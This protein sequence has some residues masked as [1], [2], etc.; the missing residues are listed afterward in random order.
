VLSL[1]VL[2]ALLSVVYSDQCMEIPFSLC[3]GEMP[4][5][6]SSG[7]SPGMT[8]FAGDAIPTGLV[9]YWSFDD[10]I[11][12]DSSRNKNPVVPVP[13]VGPGAGFGQSA[14]FNSSTGAAI[15]YLPIY[16]S[17]D[18][19]ISF[20][21]FLLAEVFDSFPSIIHKGS[22]TNP[23]PSI[24]LSESRRLHIR[25]GTAVLESTSR[26]TIGRWTSVSY[27]KDSRVVTIYIDGR[28]DAQMLLPTRAYYE[29]NK[30]HPIFLSQ[31]PFH[32][33]LDMFLDELRIYRRAVTP[34]LS[35]MSLT[36]GVHLGCSNCEFE[37]GLA[38]CPEGLHMCNQR[39]LSTSA[40][41]HARVMGW[42]DPK[43][44]TCGV[45]S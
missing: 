10:N 14:S 20:K 45:V 29:E 42:I 22:Q 7:N 13:D 9:G 11:A 19:T 38:S 40:L 21:I 36:G 39:E 25:I 41:L 32:T 17:K 4:D 3:I 33:G 24:L 44:R 18:F 5:P 31:S 12:Q 23:Q 15:A 2:L 35:S 34:A 1:W 6:T 26:I 8:V 43:K 37:K 30:P 27:V 28:L 16:Q